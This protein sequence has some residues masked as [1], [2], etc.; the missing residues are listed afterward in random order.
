MY[1]PKKDQAAPAI[2]LEPLSTFPDTATLAGALSQA[3][4]NVGRPVELSWP[5]P[6]A[7]L[8]YY[9]SVTSQ[10][11]AGDPVW[12]FT[13]G[14]GR[15][16]REIWRYASGD[17]TLIYSLVMAESTGEVTGA[18]DNASFAQGIDA[19]KFSANTASSYSTSLLG[20][21]ATSGTRYPVVNASRSSRDATMEGD[22][23]DMA[24]PNLLQSIVM[25]KMT[26][27]LFVETGQT[28][29]ELF[30]EEGNL[31]HASAHEVVGDQA[32][33]ELVT[34][35]TGKFF[36]YRDEA[37]NQRTVNRRLDAILMEGITLLDQS[38]WLMNNGV[39]MESYLDKKSANLSEGDF[40][41]AVKE[42]TPADAQLQKDFYILLDGCTS[43][44]DLLRRKPMVK[45][46]W[47]GIVFNLVNCGLVNVSKKPTRVDKTS[48]L[49][50]TAIDNTAITRVQA[51]L[52]RPDSGL[53]SY[54]S[55]HYFLNQEFQRY[56]A[57]GTPYSV[58]IF[59]MRSMKGNKLEPLSIPALK[60]A[61]LRL[62][63]ITRQL[64]V[65]AHFETLSYVLLLPNTETPSAAMLAH[66][67][68][69]TLRSTPL[70]PDADNLA[71]AFGIAGVP[72]DCRDMGLLLSAAKA[73]K[74]VAQR[75]NYPIVMFKDMQAPPA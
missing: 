20:L 24:V 52:A 46:D 74:L 45:K 35:E 69:E 38:K 14:Q 62:R 50:S 27:R 49:E 68:L 71:L 40:D 33:M 30:F 4:Q 9:L 59:E 44:F 32:I 73:S 55:F 31:L 75:N 15:D 57:Y 42:G 63:G 29:A 58:I 48:F 37:T 2:R 18:T 13:E 34:W 54:P 16:A 6:Q 21:Q 43:L 65:L 28:A 17:P 23:R 12:V 3:R 22:L 1:R 64:D 10:P 7:Q 67:M 61:M 11:Q 36:F 26:G 72:E 56:I 39:T 25:S 41:K 53:M 70:G 51:L 60:E 19:S 47:V 66:R 5:K 8:G